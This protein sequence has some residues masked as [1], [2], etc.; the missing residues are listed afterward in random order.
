MCKYTIASA[1]CGAVH[2]NGGLDLLLLLLKLCSLQKKYICFYVY[3]TNIFTQFWSALDK[4][5]KDSCD[6]KETFVFFLK[7]I[8]KLKHSVLSFSL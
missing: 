4:G 3:S 8:Q 5:N 1:S 7:F 2:Y 6:L